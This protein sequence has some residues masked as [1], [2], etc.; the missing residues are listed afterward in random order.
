MA[1]SPAFGALSQTQLQVLE[2]IRAMRAA[3]PAAPVPATASVRAAASVQVKPAAA[4]P[5]ASDAAA[6][7]MPANRPRGSILNITV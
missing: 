6:A 7:S 5:L 2:Q 4:Q 1:L 3:K